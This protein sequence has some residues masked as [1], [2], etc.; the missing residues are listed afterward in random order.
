MITPEEAWRRIA[1]EIEPLEVVQASR[2]EAAGLVLGRE[3]EARVDVPASD[4]SAMDGY[5][6]A[7]NAIRVFQPLT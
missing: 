6:L 7:G 3:L 4:V 5:A 1:A 2:A